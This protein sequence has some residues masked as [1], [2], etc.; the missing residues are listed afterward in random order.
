MIDEPS[1]D[2][3]FTNFSTALQITS[4]GKTQRDITIEPW[5]MDSKLAYKT[6]VLIK[7]QKVQTW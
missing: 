7:N 3:H 6:Q 4:K 1:E 5:D 2:P